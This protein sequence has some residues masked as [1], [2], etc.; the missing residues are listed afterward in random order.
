[1]TAPTPAT[2]IAEPETSG[3][4]RLA[5]PLRWMK[6]V[7]Q[8]TRPRQWPKN[9]L[10]FAA[11]LAGA[12]VGRHNGLWYALVAAAAFVA[13]SAAV[14]MINDVVDAERD[15][16]HPYK[17]SR[18]VAAGLLPPRHAV[19]VAVCLVLAALAAGFAIGVP[20][21]SATIAAYLIISFLYSAGLK[22]VP[23]V[24]LAC[25][26]SGFVLRVMGGAAA[27]HVPPSGWFLLVCS[28]GALMVAIAKRFTELTVL[29]TDAATHRPAM[30][31]Y[32][33][34]ALRL[35]QRG[36]SVIMIASYLLWASHEPRP[37]TKI[38]HL[39][40][41]IPLAAALARFDRLTARATSKPVEDLI[42]RDPLM[43][44]CELAWLVLFSLG[45]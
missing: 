20:G 39:L 24:E 3:S 27:T 42:A 9:L 2:Q 23:F 6:A 16:S 13:A 33:A 44:C 7:L 29:G 11:P 4:A 37:G 26:A 32:T 38:W 8:T 36:V 14:Y 35:A 17:K 12:T 15:R 10:V 28:L 40:S 18:P 22:H 45:L 5:G 31:G 41:A 43:V 30:H 34:R 19:A 1:M 25:V 21:L